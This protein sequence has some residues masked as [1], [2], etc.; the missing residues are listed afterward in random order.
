MDSITNSIKRSCIFM[1][2]LSKL[3]SLLKKHRG[4][5][6]APIYML[7]VV[8]IGAVLVVTLIKPVLKQAGSAAAAGGQ[9]ARA[10][11]GVG[12]VLFREVKRQLKN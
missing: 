8:V 1:K 3:F 11:A 7:V 12:A 6:W 5:E 4:S 9:E 2:V 10:F